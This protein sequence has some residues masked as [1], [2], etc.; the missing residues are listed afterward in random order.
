MSP[1]LVKR[2]AV[3]RVSVVPLKIIPELVKLL[4]LAARLVAAEISPAFCKSPLSA[5]ES[6]SEIE[7][8]IASE[9]FVRS[10]AT[11]LKSPIA[12]I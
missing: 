9:P 10:R 1:E 8:I 11:M 6:D 2:F 5:K 12:N 3:F 4:A 7:E